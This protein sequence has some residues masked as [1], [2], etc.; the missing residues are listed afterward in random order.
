[1]H[2]AIE[3]FTRNPVAANLL[4]FVLLV[5]GTMALLTV[6][7][8]EFPSMDVKVIVVT[9]P[10]LGAAPEEAEQ[11]V[12]I[13]IEEAL[14]G[15]DGIEKM[16]SNAVEGSCTVQAML[17]EDAEQIAVL[18]EIK[19]QVDGINTFPVETEKPIVSKVT[20]TSDVLQL[21]VS[22]K[23]DERTLK[24]VGKEL[25]EELTA[26]D[27]ISRV[28]L[29][30]V[31][32]YEISI[33]ISEYQLRR[34]GISLEQ[35][36]QVIRNTS[37]DMPG[38][39]LKT[40]GGEILLR[41]KGQAYWGTDFEDIAVVTR[42][43][44]T[45]VMLSE[46]ATIRD[47]FEEGDLK[48]RFNGDPAVVVKVWR[49]GKEDAVSMAEDIQSF[50]ER[51]QQTLPHGLTITVWNNEAQQLVYRLAALRDMALSG[52][53]LVVI[54]L[55]MFLKFR[56]AMWVAAGIPIALLGTI[57]VFPYADIS[58]SSM[59]VMAF[60]LVLG[61]L[62]DDAIVVGERVYGH[63]QMGK[64][65]V[66]AAIDGTWE[67]SVPVIFGVLT[68]MAAFLPLI[69]VEGRMA[70][71]FGVVGWVVI[72]ALVFSIIESQLILPSHLAHRNHDEAHN[73]ASR[74]WNKLQSRLSGGLE[75]LATRY[76]SPF[77]RKAVNLRYVTAAAGLGIL[78]LAL[79]LIASGRVIFTF[80]P[81]I[82][83]DKVFATLEMPEG[84]SVELTSAAAEQIER[85]AEQLAVELDEQAGTTGVVRHM[86]SSIG[87]SDDRMGRPSMMTA[88]KSHLAEVV[89]ELLPIKER[90]NISAK[91]VGNRWRELTGD[92]PDAVKLTFSADQFS[93]GAALDYELSARDV[94]LI[95]TAAADLRA[96]LSR[97]E[98]VFDVGDS[99][100]AGKQEIKLSLLPEA[101]T[102]GLTLNDLARQV[103]SAFYGAEAQRVQRGDDDVRVMVRFPE[104]ERNSIGNLED[105]YIRT[106][107]GTEVPFYSVARFELGRGY[108]TIK[109]VDGP[110]RD[111]RDRR[112]GSQHD[113]SG[114]G[115]HQRAAD[116]ASEAAR[117]VSVAQHRAVGR[118]GGTDQGI[119]GT[120]PGRPAGADRHLYA[121][122]H[123][124]TLVPAAARDHER[125]SF[126]RRGR[127]CRSLAARLSVDLLLGA[128]DRCAVRRRRELV[129]G[130]G[131]LHQSTPARR[132]VD[133]RSHTL[134]RR[135]AVPA[136]P[137]DVGDDVCGTDPDDGELDS[138]HPLFRADG[139]LS[140]VRRA[141]CNQHHTGTRAEP[142]SDRRG[143]FAL[144]S[145]CAG[146]GG[147]G[148]G[149]GGLSA[150][151]SHAIT[152]PTDADRAPAKRFYY[153]WTIVGVVAIANAISMGLAQLNMGLFVKPMGDELGISRAMF[154]WAGSLRQFAGAASSPVIGPLLDR[155]G[156]RWLLAVSTLIGAGAVMALAIVESDVQM[157]MLFGLMGLVGMSGVGQLTTSV[158]VLKW[159]VRKRSKA[160]ALM[161]IGVPAR[162]A[163]HGAAHAVVH[164]PV[165]LAYRVCTA[166]GYRDRRD[167]TAQRSVHAPP[168]RRHGP[169]RRRL[170]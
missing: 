140:G 19:S 150:R 6:H 83:G 132:H 23:T 108:S 124:I 89:L 22:G 144:G 105:M 100:R 84:V 116:R 59:T 48:A 165:G 66:R 41:A 111:Q 137:A 67:V 25:R 102:L 2:T 127:N 56:L 58:M 30:Y 94:E 115:Q 98:G 153:G 11:G 60:I 65:P 77:L 118:A 54:I 123:P 82:E 52:L 74:A 86:L 13:R 148:N 88:G 7:Q 68:T 97:Y 27:G 96:E 44:G 12:C 5:G 39:T 128:R 15:I 136:D 114:R 3:W 24:E 119:H 135:G 131:R 134:R 8:E 9:V 69:L 103:R 50:T 125:H 129:A 53:M 133:R 78:I 130:P 45:R 109:R 79:A 138:G 107:Q 141:V 85:A 117:Q 10:Y 113:E 110:A 149:Q 61:I 142:L 91:E 87:R 146:H 63:E 122:G 156:A 112:R 47:N 40:E 49:V 90:G 14:E 76:Y 162:S 73:A 106:P 35:I 166:R 46:V 155:H 16:Q 143:R 151:P 93:A 34:Y 62:V 157:L 64:T 99:F 20:V 121:A 80:F 70:G 164:R 81:A 29:R 170:A 72:I 161:S 32:P 17:F 168:A 120:R 159:F 33:E 160:V 28:E 18:N 167:R 154:G 145:D 4:M 75:T 169:A 37:L 163:D 1:M 42:A 55:T 101:R 139:D 43:D 126:W 26:I 152:S 92:I 158:P 21:A 31:R 95:R 57:A 147:T 71:F 38:G 51:Y 36:A 104:S